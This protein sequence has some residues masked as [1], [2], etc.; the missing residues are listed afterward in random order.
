M[1]RQFSELYPVFPISLPGETLQE[2]P[3]LSAQKEHTWLHEEQSDSI[4]HSAAVGSPDSISPPTVSCLQH[5]GMMHLFLGGSAGIA[6]VGWCTGGC[7]QCRCQLYTLTVTSNF[8]T[9][10]GPNVAGTIKLE[11][12]R[13][14]SQQYKP[15]V[16]PACLVVK[17][18]GTAMQLCPWDVAGGGG[19]EKPFPSWGKKK[20]KKRKTQWQFW[21]QTN[22]PF[23]N[24]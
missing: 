7:S 14:L 17:L 23:Y 4:T 24:L 10:Q 5:G 15:G 19:G 18:W 13:K 9:L 1:Y 16:Q 21:K 2:Q 12:A 6:W 8:G 22:Q 11:K 20:E 3:E